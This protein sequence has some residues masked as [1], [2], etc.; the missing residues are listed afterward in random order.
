MDLA[1]SLREAGRYKEA[2]AAVQD[3]S[4]SGKALLA[5]LLSL[6]GRDEEAWSAF[7]AAQAMAPDCP[8]VRRTHARLL[9]KSGQHDAALAEAEAA[10]RAAPGDAETILVLAGALASKGRNE[11]GVMVEQAL[12]LRPLY[13]EALALRGMLGG[14]PQDLKA[15]LDLKPHLTHL[16]APLAGLYHRSGKLGD[17]KA[18]YLNAIQGRPQPDL[19]NNV[20]TILLGE[21]KATEALE[22]F[23]RAAELNPNLAEVHSNRGKA[24]KDLGR[25]K[26]SEIAC[27]LAIHLDPKLAAAHS[28]L[29][30]VLYNAGRLEEAAEAG[31]L[32]L[33]AK[34]DFAE[35]QYDLAH[36]LYFLDEVDI[37]KEAYWKAYSMAPTGIGLNALVSLAC[38]AYA[39]RDLTGCRRLLEA[40]SQIV[41]RPE[42]VYDYRKV[43]WA[44]LTKLL[45][46]AQCFGTGKTLNV[47]GDSHSL[48]AAG[49]TVDVDG[50]A[51][52][53][54]PTLI[55]G[56][57]QWHLGNNRPHAHKVK[58]RK[59]M[60]RLSGPILLTIG[61]IDC[62]PTEG[63]FAHWKSNPGK[64]MVEVITDTVSRFVE[65]IGR[66]VI[67]SGVPAPLEGESDFVDCVR[68]FNEILKEHALAKGM[69]FLDVHSMTDDGGG[70][71]KGRWHVDRYHLIPDALREAFSKHLL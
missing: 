39:E 66:P 5:Q 70:L 67:V 52:T 55:M 58:F 23:E 46:H 63:I 68:S 51:L 36:A 48:A 34:P 65:A 49:T 13:A 27:R 10:Y 16:W 45:Q 56:C 25:L 47:V 64:P 42:P 14:N 43:Y 32:A 62:R 2:I 3:E 12:Q 28:N 59:V 40:S 9:L 22:H 20:G 50:Q 35:A 33:R 7:R 31:R 6:D 4:A 61:E 11:A 15:A 30:G 18:A 24:L 41:T 8:V 57:K 17:A 26:E 60:A 71:S 44:Y 69:R 21:G 53:V 29:A 19:H 1:V 37:A 38:F 54:V